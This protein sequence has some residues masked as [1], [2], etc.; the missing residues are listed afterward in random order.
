M[1]LVYPDT[2]HPAG[3]NHKP[4]RGEL[5]YSR[6]RVRGIHYRIARPPCGEGHQT[7]AGLSG[8]Y[9]GTETR[10][11]GN[12]PFECQPS[13]PQLTNRSPP[14]RRPQPPWHRKTRA[15][16]CSVGRGFRY[17]SLTA[18]CSS[19]AAASAGFSVCWEAAT[20]AAR[21]ASAETVSSRTREIWLMG[22][23]SPLRFSN[24]TMRV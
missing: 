3:A 17:A 23:L 13:P 14:Q 8:H 19:A 5:L 18:Y 7:G 15:T 4:G 2:A 24:F 10:S 6:N 12:K 9:P 16:T 1:L 22:A 20:R 11:W 21:L